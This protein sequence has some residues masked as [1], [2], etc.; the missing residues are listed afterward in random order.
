MKRKRDPCRVF[1]YA[2]AI[3][4]MPYY[5][6]LEKRKEFLSKF[7]TKELLLCPSEDIGHK[8]KTKKPN[9]IHQ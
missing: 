6:T 3:F 1:I 5:I 7:Q 8:P 4:A 9:K 2:F